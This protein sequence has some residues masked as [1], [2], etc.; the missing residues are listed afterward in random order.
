M[1][2]QH[3]AT[4]RQAILLFVQEYRKERK[5]FG[6]GSQMDQSIHQAL[7]ART[8]AV[9]REF[10]EVDILVVKNGTV[11]LLDNAIDLPERGH[12]FNSRFKYALEDAFA[13]GYQRIV[14]VGG[15]IPTLTAGDIRQ[16]LMREELVIGPTFDGGFYL[17][18]L[19]RADIPLFDHLPWRQPNLFEQ[20]LNRLQTSARPYYQLT[21][22]GDIDRIADARR[23]ASLLVRLVRQWCGAALCRQCHALDQTLFPPNRIPEPLFSSLPPPF[24][25]ALPH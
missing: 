25:T 17:A 18:A 14:A 13:L 22:R 3:P 11:P 2:I 5:R 9:V 12:D 20:L 10:P 23:T 24:P 21:M 6:F 16:A 15:D 7:L 19:T 8:F 1:S 4:N